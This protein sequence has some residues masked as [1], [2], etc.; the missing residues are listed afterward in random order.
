MVYGDWVYVMDIK[1]II[2]VDEYFFGKVFNVFGDILN[3]EVGVVK[4][5]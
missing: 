4:F 3:E 2:L 5:K 1:I